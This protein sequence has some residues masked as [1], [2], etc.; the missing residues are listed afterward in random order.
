M[1]LRDNIIRIYFHLATE[2]I[3]N[4]TSHL[5]WNWSKQRKR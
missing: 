5:L 3:P 1:T 2:L 4:M